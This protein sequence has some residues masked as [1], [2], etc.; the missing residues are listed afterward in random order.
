M[1]MDRRG[2]AGI[3][4]DGGEISVQMRLCVDSGGEGKRG[5]ERGQASRGVF[6]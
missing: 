2:R 1:A 5:K 4:Q 6:L 3:L